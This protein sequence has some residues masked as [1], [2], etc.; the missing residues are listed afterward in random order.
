M[1]VSSTAQFL[2][3]EKLSSKISLLMSVVSF[4]NLLLLSS[5]LSSSLKAM[6]NCCLEDILT[7]KL[8]L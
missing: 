4:S 6:L 1:V 7:L 5:Q 8:S 3:T 2:R